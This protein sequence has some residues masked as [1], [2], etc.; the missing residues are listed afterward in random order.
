MVEKKYYSTTQ[1][2]FDDDTNH[3]Q[4][5]RCSHK[6]TYSKLHIPTYCIKTSKLWVWQMTM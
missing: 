6:A 2:Q 5:V 1:R 4:K 3:S